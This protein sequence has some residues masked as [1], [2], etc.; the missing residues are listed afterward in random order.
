MHGSK[1]NRALRGVEQR[2][3]R[4]AF[5]T[6]QP[7]VNTLEFQA[8]Q[9]RGAILN[10]QVKGGRLRINLAVKQIESLVETRLRNLEQTQMPPQVAPKEVVVLEKWCRIAEQSD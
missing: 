6:R 7:D 4:Q 1:P 5:P 2:G 8:R 10:V 3:L 9:Q